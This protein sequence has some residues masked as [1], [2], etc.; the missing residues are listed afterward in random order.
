ML[1]IYLL[2]KLSPGFDNGSPKV[3]GIQEQTESTSVLSV[4]VLDLWA[5]MFSG[6]WCD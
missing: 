5:E 2:E 3:E 6:Q 1:K 4:T